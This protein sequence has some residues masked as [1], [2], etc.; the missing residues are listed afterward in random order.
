M[1]WLAYIGLACKLRMSDMTLRK[2]LHTCQYDTSKCYCLT[3]YGQS[4]RYNN[5]IIV[6]ITQK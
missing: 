6:E 3:R 1:V 5:F 4:I 2:M